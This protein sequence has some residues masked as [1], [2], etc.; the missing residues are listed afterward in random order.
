MLRRSMLLFGPLAAS[1]L[2]AVAG[3]GG[4]H[5]AAG[6][7]TAKPA[8]IKP[9]DGQYPILIVCTT[10][11]VADMLHNIGG[12]HIAVTALMGPGVDPHLY[13]ESP[14]DIEKLGRA[15]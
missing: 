8:A 14:S 7:P 2:A 4:E 13:R 1:L 5:S 12:D 6:E 3:C 15:D 11:Q 9:F 10:G